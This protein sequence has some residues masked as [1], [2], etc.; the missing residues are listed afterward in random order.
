VTSSG[1]V[2]STTGGGGGGGVFGACWTTTTAA[3]AA[4][5]LP[6]ASFAVNVTVVVPSG[7]VAGALFVTVGAG[8]AMSWATAE[9]RKAAIAGVEAGT[10]VPVVETVIGAGTVR[11]GGVVS[12]M[13]MVNVA[14]LVFAGV[15][16]SD[17]LQVT[18]CVPIERSVPGG[19]TQVTGTGPATASTAVGSV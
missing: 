16:L 9:P 17:A 8:S 7:N 3:D 1:G 12:T 10:L 18:V 15:A 19:G 2:R 13:S 5:V 11:T 14:V 4:D 6:E